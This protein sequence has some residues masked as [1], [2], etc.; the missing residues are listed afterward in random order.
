MV[1]RGQ[2]RPLGSPGSATLLS[3]AYGGIHPRYRQQPRSDVV[4]P[5]LRRRCCPRRGKS[6]SWII[7]RSL[8]RV[9]AIFRRKQNRILLEGEKI[10]STKLFDH[11]SRS[12][13]EG[14]IRWKV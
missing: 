10:E 2:Q 12:W 4:P 1:H 6:S 8:S 11:D 3:E 14:R 13:P 9:S 5:Q 7:R